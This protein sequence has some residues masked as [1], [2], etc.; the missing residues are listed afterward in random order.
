MPAAILVSGS[1]TPI[2]RF[3]GAFRDVSAPQLAAVTLQATLARAGLAPGQV[4]DVILGQVLPAGVGQA[5][6]RQ[7][8]LAAGLPNTISACTVNKVC[9]SGLQAV[10]LAA[11]AVRAGDSRVVLAGGMENMSRAPH[12]LRGVREGLKFGH[13]AVEDSMLLDGLTCALEHCGMGEHAEFTAREAGLTRGDQDEFAL[14]SQTRAAQAQTRGA[15]RAELVPVPVRVKGQTVHV[16]TDEGIR[17]ETTLETLAKL[18]PAFDPAGSVTAGNSS[19]LA[20]GAASVA[21]VDEATAATLSTP[22]KFRVLASATSGGEPRRLFFAPINAVRQVVAK[23][24][25]TV[26]DIDLFEINEAFASQTVACVRGLGLDS[27]RVNVNGGAIAL[28]HP[29]G[30]SGARVLVTLL[31]EL[32]ARQARR[33]IATLCLGGGNAV[34]LLVERHG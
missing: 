5:P 7:A 18:R 2:G 32:H 31:W 3:L 28:G 19:T 30:A 22:W 8:A 9:G 12:L 11:Q 25:L 26:A 33:G 10:M 6:A 29:I 34:A 23:A 13:S 17:P 16:E 20:D 24:G 27:G 15:F 21:V 1:R 4:D 14:A